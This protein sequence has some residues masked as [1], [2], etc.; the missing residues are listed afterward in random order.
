[1]VNRP[2]E[3]T[4]LRARLLGVKLKALVGDHLGSPLDV[5]PQ[6]FRSGAGLVVDGR[7]WVLIDGD[8]SRSLGGAVAWAI[9]HDAAS[10]DVIA[11]SATGLLARRAGFF[12]LPISIWFAEKRLL[13]PVVAEPHSPQRAPSAEHTDLVATIEAG[14]AEPNIEHGVVTGEVRG[15]E[16]CRVVDEPTI[17]RLI[18][19]GEIE[20]SGQLGEPGVRLEVGVGANDR[21]AFQLLHGD[22]PTI[23]A[24]SGVVESVR[25]HR[26]ADAPQHP[27][28][29]M[30]PERFLRWNAASAPAS[31]GMATIEP[32]AAPV[33]RP[34][35]KD[36]APAVALGSDVDGAQH[37]LVFS[38]GV[39]LDLVPFALD[40]HA[41]LAASGRAEL[42]SAITLVLRES[43]LVAIT[44]DIAAHATAPIEFVLVN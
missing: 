15:L 12:S 43:D 33:P 14:G 11:E 8:A 40:A 32:V 18:D 24:L 2:G 34:S 41:S 23:E 37:V 13:L 39:D 26:S 44:R 42:E 3:N 36:Q 9:R 25:Q 22:L 28:N 19:I 38:N 10:L 7:A 35:M 21:E 27:L 6:G 17:G 31:L 16:V 30:A 5:E 20:L 4:E 29:R 1:M